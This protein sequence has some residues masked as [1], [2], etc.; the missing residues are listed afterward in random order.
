MTYAAISIGANTTILKPVVTGGTLYSDSTYYYRKF[1]AS[2]SFSVAQ[3]E[4]IIDYLM[5]GGGGAG[6][7]SATDFVVDGFGNLGFRVGGGGGGGGVLLQTN[8]TFSPG[9]AF[10]LV[11]GGGTASTS[12]TSPGGD[13]YFSFGRVA[14]GGGNGWASAAGESGINT[15]IGHGG[16]GYGQV[17]IGDGAIQ[18]VNG[19]TGSIGNGGGF[20]IGGGYTG[21]A[22]YSTNNETTCT[23]GG[24]AGAGGNG[25]AP[26]AGSGIFRLRGGDGGPGTNSY[27]GTSFSSWLSATTSAGVLAAGGGG[28]TNY[29]W[30]T[31][32]IAGVG[33]GAGGTPDNNGANAIVNTGSGGG[34][35]GIPNTANRRV[36]GNGGSGLVIVRY[37]KAQVD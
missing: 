2:G 21:G 10:V 4:L 26:P 19:S 34:G 28:G 14:F 16:G 37:T 17:R 32:G 18:G 7:S 36:G 22:G 30:P 20:I 1:T 13:T 25:F 33:G 24:G 27:S 9:S 12:S 23:G 11:G 15:W 35:A 5:L 3:K 6:G 29:N 8:A 31:G